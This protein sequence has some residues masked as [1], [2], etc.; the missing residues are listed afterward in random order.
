MARP[1]RILRALAAGPGPATLAV[2]LCI[3]LGL[4]DTPLIPVAHTGAVTAAADLEGAVRSPFRLAAQQAEPDLAPLR[5]TIDSMSRGTLPRRGSI[6]VRGTVSNQSDEIWTTVKLYTFLGSDLAPMSDPAALDAAMDVPYEAQV[7]ERLVDVG[8][9]GLIEV[10]EPGESAS[11]V[12]KVPVS[13]FGFVDPDQPEPG[14]Y[15]FGVHALGQGGSLPRDNVADGRARTFLPVVGRDPETVPT[16]LV[17]PMVQGVRYNSDGSLANEERWEQHLTPGGRLDDLLVLGQAAAAAGVP[18]TWL[19]DPALL[20]AIG[21]LS[22][23]NPPRSLSPSGPVAS[24]VPTSS[25]SSDA[26]S[27]ASPAPGEL[28]SPGPASSS[29]VPTAGTDA[30]AD[31]GEGDG[32]SAETLPDTPAGLAA[33]DWLRQVSP[34][35]RRG[36]VLT[37]PYGNIDIGGALRSDPALLDLARAQEGTVLTALGI[38][39]EPVNAAPGGYVDAATARAAPTDVPLLVSDRFLTANV[40]NIAGI[41]GNEL[42]ITSSGAAQG[43]PGPGRSLTPVGL[44][45]RLLAEAAVRSLPASD[46]EGSVGGEPLVVVLPTDWRLSAA[47]QL[48]DRLPA[49]WIDYGSLSEATDDQ[50]VQQISA[51]DLLVVSDRRELEP[52]T[53]VAARELID[54]GVTLQRVLVENNALGARVTEEA[55]SGLS[56]SVRGQQRGVRS[57]LALSRTWLSARLGSVQISA[58]SGVTLSGDSGTFVVTLTNDLDEAVNV[59]VS[60]SSDPGLSIAAVDAVEVGARSRISVLLQATTTTSRVHNVTLVVTDAT[61]VPLGASESL[62]IRSVLVSDVIWVIIGVGVGTLFLAILLRLRR[63]ILAGRRNGPARTT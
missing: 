5:V 8:E 50:P 54:T 13:E 45:Q 33:R 19:V 3:P 30:D 48:F 18:L 28:A 34:L 58:S 4:S 11:Y 57:S 21:Q 43:S 35:L 16:A 60:A 24:P 31:A 40:P 63:R 7:G 36:E 22:S 12:V 56:Y 62:P 49:E 37:L 42:I 51:E 10:L 20:D 6:K 53:F 9:P 29:P 27:G 61:G 55:L 52:E 32:D 15:W 44:R 26:G 2:A 23:G 59:S 41:G 46:D 1:R 14:A 38:E 39:S 17:V 47:E 25:A